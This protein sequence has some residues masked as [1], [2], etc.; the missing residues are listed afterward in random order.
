[1]RVSDPRLHKHYGREVR[2]FDLALWERERENIVLV[3]SYAKFAHNPAI[4]THLLDK[5]DKLIAEA[6]PYDLIWGTGYRDGAIPGRH[7][8]L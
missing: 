2:N 7:P 1:M 6:S 5:G 8:P 3:G 4:Q